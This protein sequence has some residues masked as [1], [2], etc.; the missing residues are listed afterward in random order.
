MKLRQ[1]Y[2]AIALIPADGAAKLHGKRLRIDV[3]IDVQMHNF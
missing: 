2:R 3:W 1:I